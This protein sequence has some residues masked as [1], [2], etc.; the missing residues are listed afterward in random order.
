MTKKAPQET[1]Q[2]LIE[3]AV[4][5]FVTDPTQFTLDAV[6]AKAKVSKGG[7]LHHFPNKE[8]LLSGIV[9]FA[10]QVW[11]NRLAYELEQE[12]EGVPGR[13][14][15]AY[16]RT[17]F[18]LNEQEKL[19]NAALR[20]MQ[21]LYPELLAKFEYQKWNIDRDDGLP[22]GRALVIQLACD[23]LWLTEYVDMPSLTRVELAQ[24]KEE[25]ERLTK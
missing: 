21:S 11:L 10:E 20:N 7:L 4:A 23:G 14:C 12:P 22:P 18:D 8:A 3:A 2:K 25:L 13:W 1:R 19:L 24:L 6:V 15:R 17:C 16:I 5:L 9:E